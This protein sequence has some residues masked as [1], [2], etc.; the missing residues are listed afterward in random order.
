MRAR[1]MG[2]LLSG[3]A[4]AGCEEHEFHPPDRAAQVAVADSQ[5]AQ[6]RF[7][8]IAWA[9]EDARI[10]VGNTTFA[11]HCTRCHGPLGRGGTEYVVE[12]D[13]DVPS[14]VE[15]GWPYEGDTDAVRRRVWV[16][17]PQGM[18]TW[19]VAR[20]TLREVDAVA[21]YIVAQLRP[22]VLGGG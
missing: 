12:Q 9:A 6:L 10:E 4:A 17:H 7:D 22:E 15:P 5:Y 1:A 13:L 8:T 3:L 11:A 20:L 2:V 16:G 18:P 14:L 19:G 21:H